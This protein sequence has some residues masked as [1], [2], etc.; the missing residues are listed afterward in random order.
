MH[1]QIPHMVKKYYVKLCFT[2]FK[3]EII[4]VLLGLSMGFIWRRSKE[5]KNDESC[6]DPLT[7][8]RV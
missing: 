5:M 2:Q 3:P 4:N 8:M 1:P 6:G 7:Q